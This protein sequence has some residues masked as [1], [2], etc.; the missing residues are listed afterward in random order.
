MRLL[1]ATLLLA[2]AG[3]GAVNTDAADTQMV[4]A[5]CVMPSTPGEF[6]ARVVMPF[7]GGATVVPN[8]KVTLHGKQGLTFQ[9]KTDLHGDVKINDVMP[10]V[11]AMTAKADG[12]F[13]CYAMHVLAQDDSSS[14]PDSAEITCALVGGRQFKSTITPYLAFDQTRDNLTADEQVLVKHV[15]RVSNVKISVPHSS[16]HVAVQMSS[17]TSQP[18]SDMN[19][20][21]FNN[22][23]LVARG[24][25]DA[26]G[27][28]NFRG[29]EPGVYSVVSV[30]Q[31]GLAAVGFELSESALTSVSNGERTL[32]AVQDEAAD[33]ALELEVIPLSAEEIEEVLEEEEESEEED[34]DEDE[35]EDSSMLD[36][37]GNPIEEVPEEGLGTPVAGGGTGGGGVAGGGGGG[38]SGGLG[39]AAGVAAIAGIAAAAS[40]GSSDNIAVP[41]VASLATP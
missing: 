41:P 26:T 3:L 38:G 6:K 40:N 29:L 33:A 2:L 31:Q 10:G 28:Y 5:Q 14:C 8:T 17:V 9:G 23:K 1:V 39:P 24:V 25:S 27:T 20:F 11:Y 32:V 7:R 36:E 30:G 18:A 19:V 21:L 12:L 4:V 37:D 13:A 15:S 35:E 34:E 16:G 22:R